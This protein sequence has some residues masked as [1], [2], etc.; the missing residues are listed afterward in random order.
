[1]DGYAAIAYTDSAVYGTI[2]RKTPRVIRNPSKPSREPDDQRSAE[3]I[4]SHRDVGAP[5]IG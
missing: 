5:H 2:K 1:M 4:S 3:T